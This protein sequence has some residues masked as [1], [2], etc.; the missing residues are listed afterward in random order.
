MIRISI[1]N[2]ME[3]ISQNATVNDVLEN[4][5]YINKKVAVAINQE[6][7]AKENYSTTLI[8]DEDCIDIISP[9]AGG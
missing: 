5:K 2:E 7:I 1:N 4:F 3:E 6:F 9:I 8:Q